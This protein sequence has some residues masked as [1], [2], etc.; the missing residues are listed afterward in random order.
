MAK[1]LRG[2]VAGLQSSRVHTA[3][4]GKSCKVRFGKSEWRGIFPRER[5]PNNSSQNYRL[6]KYDS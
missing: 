1:I 3:A 5:G 6:E 4:S 2:V